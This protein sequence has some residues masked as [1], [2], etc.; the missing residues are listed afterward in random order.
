MFSWLNKKLAKI[1]AAPKPKSLLDYI[2]HKE[3]PDCGV[4][5]M[6]GGPEG[7][8]SQNILCANC[9]SEFNWAQRFMADRISWQDF[10]ELLA[11][12]PH[13]YPFERAIWKNYE[14]V[15]YN[16]TKSA[17][18]VE[19]CKENCAGDWS[20]KSAHINLRSWDGGFYFF[21]SNR[22]DATRFKLTWA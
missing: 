2:D 17:E 15:P 14:H 13:F 6:R 3:C 12:Q 11:E 18:G 9:G 5:D 22:D 4:W 20:I 7:G 8:M 19:W 1:T 10:G 21:F 16:K